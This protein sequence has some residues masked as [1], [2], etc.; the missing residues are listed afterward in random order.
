[1]YGV[2]IVL[3][4]PF[5]LGT[6]HHPVLKVMRKLGNATPSTELVDA[7]LH[8]IAKAYG[9]AWAP[10]L[11]AYSADAAGDPADVGDR[12]TSAVRRVRDHQDTHV[13]ADIGSRGGREGIGIDI[14]PR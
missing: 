13:S 5:A 4:V 9:V 10:P 7:Y 6:D 1:M 12:S 8:E 2:Y 14:K 3:L 11:P